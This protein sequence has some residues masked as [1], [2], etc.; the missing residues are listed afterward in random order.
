VD[1]HVHLREPGQQHKE[2]IIS[3]TQAAAAGGFTTVCCMPNTEP[4]LDNPAIID[5][6]LD[7]SASPESGGCL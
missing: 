5:Y 6:I 1:P 4:A 2:T 7:K 3:G